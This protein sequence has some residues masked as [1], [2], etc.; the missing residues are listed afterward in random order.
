MINPDSHW[1]KN[2]MRLNRSVN[3]AIG[4]IIKKRVV[5]T[6]IKDVES[7]KRWAILKW[8]AKPEC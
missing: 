4:D 8:Y 1:D 3:H 5:L 6:T 7:V 2:T